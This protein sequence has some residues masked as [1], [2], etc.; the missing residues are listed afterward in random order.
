M[1]MTMTEEQVWALMEMI[2]LAIGDQQDYLMQG[3][4]DADYGD[5]W[6]QVAAEKAARFRVVA[7]WIKTNVGPSGY[8]S[9]LLDLATSFEASGYEYKNPEVGN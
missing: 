6:P 3:N 2:S 8:V 7:E 9:D 1:T 5:E 4:P